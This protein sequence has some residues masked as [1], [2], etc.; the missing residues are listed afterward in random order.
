MPIAFL[1]LFTESSYCSGLEKCTECSPLKDTCRNP[2]GDPVD[3]ENRS[4][5]VSD[6]CLWL[7]VCRVR[8]FAAL[9]EDLLL[10]VQFIAGALGVC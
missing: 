10:S 2:F 6:L 8:S 4:L 3:R 1:M 7:C 5:A 9:P